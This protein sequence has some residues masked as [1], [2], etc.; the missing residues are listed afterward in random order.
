MYPTDKDLI[1]KILNRNDEAWEFFIVQYTPFIQKAINQV[2]SYN[3]IGYIVEEIGELVNDIFLSLLENDYKR[4]RQFRG[5]SKL[6][7]W[8]FTVSEN[9]T[10][11][12]LRKQ[13]ALI[14]IISFEENDDQKPQIPDKRPTAV[15][16]LE[17]I[18]VVKSV[19]KELQDRLT[20]QEKNFMQLHYFQDKALPA[21]ADEMNISINNVYVIKHRVKKKGGKILSEFTKYKKIIS[22]L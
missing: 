2:L 15:E 17:S 13:K 18:E 20:D 10:K 4:L 3:Q 16:Q 14:E 12:F 19:F 21:V 9:K 8:L 6:S 22:R 5:E 7:T 11:D 1:E